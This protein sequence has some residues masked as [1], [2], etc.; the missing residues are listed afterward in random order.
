MTADPTRL[1]NDAYLWSDHRWCTRCHRGYASAQS[2]IRDGVRWCPY[3]GCQAG[4]L[5]DSWD[6][7]LVLVVH[8]AFPERPVWDEVY[9]VP[10][11]R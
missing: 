1:S 8:P 10:E 9:E 3:P 4:F 6:W 7:A 2:L 5:G 11:L